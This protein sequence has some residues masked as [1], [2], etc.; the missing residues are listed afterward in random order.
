MYSRKIKNILKKIESIENVL[1]LRLDSDFTTANK[2]Q[3][4]T[5]CDISILDNQ[6]A[7]NALED[8]CVKLGFFLSSKDYSKT[9]YVL[10]LQDRWVQLD[11]ATNYRYITKFFPNNSLRTDCI[12]Q[13]NSNTTRSTFIRYVLMLRRDEKAL[14]FIQKNWLQHSEV[15]FTNTLTTHP[16]IT[17]KNVSMEILLSAL[18]RKKTSLLQVFSFKQLRTITLIKIRD[19][20]PTCTRGSLTAFVG[21]DGSGKTTIIN[22]LQCIYQKP[23]IM[24]GGDK[25]FFLQKIYDFLSGRHVYVSSISYLGMFI[26]NLFRYMYAFIL[27]RTGHT[28]FFDRYPGFNNHLKTNNLRKKL[29]IALYY[30]FPNPDTIIFLQSDAQQI[31]KRKPELQV[32][33]IQRYQENILS[34]RKTKSIQI[35]KNN[36]IEG[37]LNECLKYIKN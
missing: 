25:K 36:T 15:L 1:V 10:Y 17:K 23:K 28:V 13:L 12:N 31:H 26:E 33:E 24:Y 35:I 7:L 22:E 11:I 27:S 8:L 3:T 21:P 9:K 20:L 34:L 32:D 2:Q 30:F 14:D 4:I 6:Q 29:S 19:K 16:I 18:S 5:E 37:T